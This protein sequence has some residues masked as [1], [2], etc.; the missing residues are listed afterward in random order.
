MALLSDFVQ[1]TDT[2]LAKGGYT[3]INRFMIASRCVLSK[4]LDCRQDN[5]NKPPYAS[6]AS[7][8]SLRVYLNPAGKLST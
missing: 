2:M 1:G 7:R 3:I 4:L 6:L 5:E 8:S